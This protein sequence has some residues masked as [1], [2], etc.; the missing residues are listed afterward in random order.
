MVTPMEIQ[1]LVLV[2]ENWIG[3]HLLGR[4]GGP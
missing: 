4:G 1:I 2:T 3:R